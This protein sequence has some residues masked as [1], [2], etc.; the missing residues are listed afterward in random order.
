MIRGKSDILTLSNSDLIHEMAGELRDLKKLELDMLLMLD[1]RQYR[2][3]AK[4]PVPKRMKSARGVRDRALRECVRTV[5]K[6]TLIW[7][8]GY[9]AWRARADRRTPIAN[10]R[11]CLFV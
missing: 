11:Y 6:Y 9:S 8:P 2:L 3:D 1:P 10:S 5:E 7:F 4:K